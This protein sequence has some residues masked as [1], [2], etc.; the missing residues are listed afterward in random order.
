MHGETLVVESTDP[1]ER[2]HAR[3]VARAIE[4][5]GGRLIDGG[6]VAG[7]VLGHRALETCVIDA[8]GDALARVRTRAIEG[9]VESEIVVF[10]RPR[11]TPWREA[12]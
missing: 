6:P 2:S 9:D 12:G 7:I 4:S 5:L 1:R 3:A 8:L 11:G 10:A